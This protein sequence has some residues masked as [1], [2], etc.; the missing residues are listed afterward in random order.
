MLRDY[1]YVDARGIDPEF[2]A[3]EDQLIVALPKAQTPKG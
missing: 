3:T 1:G 2:K